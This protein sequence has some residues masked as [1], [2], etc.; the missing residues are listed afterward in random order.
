MEDELHYV[1][2]TFRP[3]DPAQENQN[4]LETIYT[5][6]KTETKTEAQAWD[7]PPAK[8]A[9]SEDK[10]PRRPLLPKRVVVL[11]ICVTVVTITIAVCIHFLSEQ[12][13]QNVDLAAL[14]L[15]LWAEQASLQRQVEELLRATERLNWTMS[16]I[17]EYDVFPVNTHCPH[18]VCRPCLD[19]WLHFQ[20]KCLLISKSPHYSGWRNWQSSQDHCRQSRAELVVIE[21]QEEQE[22]INNHTERYHDERHGYWIGLSNKSPT[23]AWTWVDGSNVTVSFWKTQ[24]AASMLCGLSLP[25]A[26]PLA[27][28][29]QEGCSMKN[30]WICQTRALIKNHSSITDEEEEL[31][32]GHTVHKMEGEVTYS[33]VVIK[34]VPPSTGEAAPSTGEAAPPSTGEAAPSRGEAAPSRGEA[35]PSRENIEESTVYSEVKRREAPAAALDTS[36][37][38]T[39]PRLLL[40]GFGI[41]VVLLVVC[42]IIIIYISIVMSKQEVTLSDQAAQHQQLTEQLKVLKNTTSRLIRDGDHLNW[43]LGVI[44]TFSNFPVT[45]FCP[46]RKCRPCQD[47]WLLFQEKCY[48]FYDEGAPWK[49]WEA[50]RRFCQNTAADL[51]VVDGLKEQEFLRNHSKWY[52]D[53][54]HGFW[55]GLQKTHGTGTWTWIDGRNDTLGFW[56]KEQLGTP[57]LCGLMIPERPV[58]GSW[59]PADCMMENKFICEADVLIKSTV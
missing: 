38:A 50:S 59:D 54:D 36:R 1:R 47:G 7:A 52:Y 45:K 30:R 25:H 43:T 3:R 41:A 2:V 17:L 13:R 39:S 5:E 46:D 22:F 56:V 37:T 26:D 51:V 33:T 48:L 28:W 27:N 16:V 53:N 21:S 23:E 57:G 29:H 42:C 11:G 58:N 14:N 10:A 20:S 49:T 31:S 44:L 19:G 8:A 12:H 34:K 40:V 6:V 32:A 24:R 4:N 9:G 55:L 15:Q 18:K 35:A